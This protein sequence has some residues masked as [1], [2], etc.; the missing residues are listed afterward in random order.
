MSNREQLQG[1]VCIGTYVIGSFCM[2]GTAEEVGERRFADVWETYEAHFEI[3]FDAA[4]A[5]R[6]HELVIGFIGFVFAPA[7]CEFTH[8]RYNQP[9]STSSKLLGFRT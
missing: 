8:T 5:S 1:R 6:A 4:K 9:V 3:V 2:T 7:G